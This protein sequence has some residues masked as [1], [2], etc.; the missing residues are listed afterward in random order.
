MRTLL[1]VIFA[2]ITVTWA[3]Y[4]FLTAQDLP[5]IEVVLRP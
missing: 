2:L 4:T 1:A 5:P 3:S